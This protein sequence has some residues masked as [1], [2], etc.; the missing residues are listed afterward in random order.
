MLYIGRFRWS[1]YKT[2]KAIIGGAYFNI[3]IVHGLQNIF[4]ADHYGQLLANEGNG[5]LLHQVFGNP[6]SGIFC[7]AEMTFDYCQFYVGVTV[8]VLVF[9]ALF[10]YSGQFGQG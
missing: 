3:G 2:P 4:F 8:R 10:R 7:Y 5:P 6:H 1:C 9:P